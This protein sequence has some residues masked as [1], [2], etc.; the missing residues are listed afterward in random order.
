MYPRVI[1]LNLRKDASSIYLSVNLFLID[2]V[3]KAGMY[4]TS[5]GCCQASRRLVD[6]F[7]RLVRVGSSITPKLPLF[8]YISATKEN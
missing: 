5:P 3:V 1:F 4:V 7:D 8:L 2:S 6:E